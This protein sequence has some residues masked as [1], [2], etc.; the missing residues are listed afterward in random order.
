MGNIIIVFWNIGWYIDFF[1]I[2]FFP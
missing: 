2:R 1:F